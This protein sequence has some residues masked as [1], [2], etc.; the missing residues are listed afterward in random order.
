M[1]SIRTT[2]LASDPPWTDDVDAVIDAA[3]AASREFR[4]LDQ[5]RVDA[6]VEAMVR[7][8]LRAAAELA[9]VAIQ[10]TGFGVFEDKVVKNYVATE[11]LHDYLRGK[12]SVGVIDEDVENNICYV[13]E[14]IGVV[15]AITPVTN[16][17]STVLFK[18]IVAA[19]TR[20]A[21][22]FRP[23]PYAVRCCERSVQ[24]LREAAEAAGMPRGA[25]Q[26]IPDAE[27]AV[28]HHL[29]EHPE[30]DF[31][32]VTGGPKI[33]A[34]ANASGKPGISVG[35]GNAPIYIHRTADIKGAVV[36]ILISKTFDSSVIC[37]AEQTCIIDDEIYDATIAEFEQMGAQLLSDDEAAKVAEFAFGCADKIALEAVGQKAS[38]LAARAGFTV[39]PTV[40]ILL[41]VLP[42]DLDE[43]AAHPLVAE[44]LMPVLGV[45]RARDVQHGIDAAVLVTEH[46][47]LGHTSAIY[48]GDDDVVDRYAQAVRTG[49]ILVNAP[50]AVGALGGIYNNLTPTFSLG[51]GTWGG[52]S[53]TE[54]VNYR[55]L[56]NIKTVARRRTP[57]Q[58]FRVPS[59]TYFNEG[60]LDNLRDLDCETVVVVTDALTEERGVADQIRSKLRAPHV[61]VFSEV[62][63]E[64][65]DALIRRG[66]AVLQRAEPDV[67]IAVG[68]GSVLDAAK[69]MRLFYEHPEMNLEE[70][71][72]PFLDPRKRVAEFPS[73]H[74]R[75]QLVAIPTTSGT[76]S[77]VSPAAVLT[78]DGRK[79]TLVD[80]SLVPDL[81]IV[82]PSLTASMPVT[83][84]AD[85]GIDALTHAL[86]AVI[87]IFASS[88]TDALCAQA[89]RLIFAALPRA[90]KNPHDLAARTDMS[91]AATLAGLAFSNA[92]V[93]TNHAL[94]HAA[95]AKFGIAHGRANGIFLPHVMRYNAS[96]P[97]KFMPA[98]G[99]SAYVVPEKYAQIGQ[100]VFG[101]H[102]PADSRERLFHAVE[103]LLDQL[104]MPRS[105]REYGVPED[106]F[107]AAL[108][109]LAMT[110]FE[111]LSNR[112]NPRMPLVS[113]I[114]ELLQL[115]Y[116]GVV[117]AES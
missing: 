99:Y 16:P 26:V 67:L 109:E 95:G 46:G 18:A 73:D 13:A 17:T 5:D 28:T 96:L 57:P 72:M 116:Y 20:N 49:R 111:D 104:D 38:E 70:L 97:T 31:V 34:L 48:A 7:A 79:E 35:P 23:S 36:D 27:H 8:G 9:G 52:S 24:V 90:Y 112:T 94:A 43:L 50:T 25:L 80:Y 63:P 82:D 103:Q 66:V 71:T 1:T 59:N 51:C 12:K 113:E 2:E 69:A 11:F 10:E 88:Y 81:A 15:L 75:V 41:A 87:S 33:V 77:E 85:T 64:P 19:K 98:P 44:K 29:F 110:A 32:W 101:G 60:A 105:L 40:K 78:V 76:G 108:P 117:A 114:T 58:W 37:P 83:L 14:P 84:T 62:T 39:S 68:G 56:L 107:V 74:H 3:A 53:T 6:I 115:G 22:V 4:A 92:F 54:N 100:L 61:Q 93:G 55:Q 45:V 86:E 91:N 21:I 42:A 102:E 30:V 65:D 106:E 47:G 89:V